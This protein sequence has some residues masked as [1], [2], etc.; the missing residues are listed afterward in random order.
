MVRANE[1]L[2]AFGELESG[3]FDSPERPEDCGG[4]AIKFDTR[5][6]LSKKLFDY[7][8]RRLNA[9]SAGLKKPGEKK[10]HHP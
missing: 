10:S 1:K 8:I 4:R 6:G 5:R 3:D 2:T 7:V 9:S